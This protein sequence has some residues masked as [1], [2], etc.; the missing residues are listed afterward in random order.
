MT[1]ARWW[2]LLAITIGVVAAVLEAQPWVVTLAI[3]RFGGTDQEIQECQ[4]SIGSGAMLVLHPKGEPCQ[5]ARE[6]VGRTG[7]LMFVVD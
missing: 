4:F 3:G 2:L 7:T 1:R 6:L 5:V